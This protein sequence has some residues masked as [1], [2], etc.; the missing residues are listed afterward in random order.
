MQE[1][2]DSSRVFRS[3][4]HINKCI[5]KIT[6]TCATQDSING[7]KEK[8]N[9]EEI[10]NWNAGYRNIISLTQIRSFSFVSLVRKHD[11]NEADFNLTPLTNTHTHIHIHIH[12]REKQL[13][14]R[15]ASEAYV[16]KAEVDECERTDDVLAEKPR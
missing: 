14:W 7:K 1:A 16:R 8:R 11:R 4:A 10:E 15:N 6:K 5:E 2:N 3:H 9:E 12:I 13:Q